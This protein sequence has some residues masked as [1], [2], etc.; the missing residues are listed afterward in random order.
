[1]IGVLWSLLGVLAGA[2]I[3][4]QAPVNSELSRGLGFPVAAAAISFLAGAA[5][6]GLVSTVIVKAQGIALD[7]RAPAPWL[8]IA[9]GCLGGA[10]VTTATILA[11]RLGAAS[12]M[13]FM[14]TGQLLTGMLIDRLGLFGLAVR[15]V[16]V[17][18]IA[19][20]LLLIAGA[21]MIRIY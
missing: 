21:L 3:A 12:L 19:G 4:V 8:F 18:R 6:L 11:P 20:A 17:G 7:W 1:M 9:G 14:V 5:V 16:S 2:F 15:E 13:A 10:Y